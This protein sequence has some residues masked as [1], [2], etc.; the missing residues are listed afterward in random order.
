MKKTF[1]AVAVMREARGKLAGE[2]ENKPR[3]EEIDSLRKKYSELTR[4]KKRA[5]R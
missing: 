1:D 5:K 2:W 3:E 4:R